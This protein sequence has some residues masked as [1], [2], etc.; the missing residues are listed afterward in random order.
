M[1][2]D[3]GGREGL[4]D[5]DGVAGAE[6]GSTA[7]GAAAATECDE[8]SRLAVSSERVMGIHPTAS[9]IGRPRLARPASASLALPSRLSR[10]GERRA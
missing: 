2:D 5:A 7:D 10:R 3:A 6:T 4:D 8:R 1:R 9:F